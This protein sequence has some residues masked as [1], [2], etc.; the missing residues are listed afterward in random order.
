[1]KHYFLILFCFV[2][3]NSFAQPALNDTV[4]DFNVVDVH[5]DS[6]HL[7]SYLEE[8]KFVCIDFYG[9]TCDQCRELVPII[10]D[11]YKSY[12]CNESQLVVL[13]IDLLHFDGEVQAFEEEYGGIYPA[14]SGKNGGGEQ[15]YSDWQIQYWPQLVLINPERVLVSNIHPISPVLIDSVLQHHQILKDSCNANGVNS[16]LLKDYVSVYPNPSTNFLNIEVAE[17]YPSKMEIKLFNPLGKIVLETS[18]QKRYSLNTS[19]YTKGVY[20]LE[21]ECDGKRA[22]EKIIIK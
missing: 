7:Y 17:Q 16:L 20:I 19:N 3:A 14:V 8:G 2:I 13:A 1:M 11:V 12:G 6:H 10:S 5:G 15:V 9:T 21:I 22:Y 18:F 4:P